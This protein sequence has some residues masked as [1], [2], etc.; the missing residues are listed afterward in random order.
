MGQLKGQHPNMHWFL[1]INNS[2][3]FLDSFLQPVAIAPH[4]NMGSRLV[5]VVANTSKVCT[6]ERNIV[7]RSFARVY[8]MKLSGN[9]FPVAHQ[10]T[11]AS[12]TPPTPDLPVISVWLDVMAVFRRNSKPY[13]LR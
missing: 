3:P 11:E 2:L 8:D 10:L 7:E 13:Y 12:G 5:D 1:P 9:K 6:S 4:G